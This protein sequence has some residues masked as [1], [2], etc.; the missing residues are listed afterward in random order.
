MIKALCFDCG[1]R[2]V[3]LRTGWCWLCGGD[4]FPYLPR[5]DY[6]VVDKSIQPVDQEPDPCSPQS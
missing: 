4:V 5:F 6:A 1:A 3:H 2:Y